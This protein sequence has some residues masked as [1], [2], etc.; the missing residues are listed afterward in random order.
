MN[1]A[2]PLIRRDARADH[3]LFFKFAN[4]WVYFCTVLLL[5]LLLLA[6]PSQCYSKCPRN[7]EVHF[8]IFVSGFWLNS[9]GNETLQTVKNMFKKLNDECAAPGFHLTYAVYNTKCE[10]DKGY[11][12]AVFSLNK[13]GIRV[14]VGECCLYRAAVVNCC[15]LLMSIFLSLSVYLSICLCLCLSLSV[16]LSVCLSH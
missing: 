1:L 7:T 8:G 14:V 2:C 5:L 13:K 11:F 4:L 10:V 6:E 3:A 15:V 16:C 9:T 12:D